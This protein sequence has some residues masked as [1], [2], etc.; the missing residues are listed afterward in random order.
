MCLVGENAGTFHLRILLFQAPS[1]EHSDTAQ[2][3]VNATPLKF[4]PF[5][6]HCIVAEIS[7]LPAASSSEMTRLATELAG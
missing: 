5:N 2:H 4:E 7:I 6:Q 3:L 1:E